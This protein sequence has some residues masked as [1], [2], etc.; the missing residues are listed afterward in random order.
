MIEETLERIRGVVPVENVLVLTNDDQIAAVRNILADYLPAENILAEPAKRDTAPAIAIAV[1]W[2]ASQ[3]RDASM[4]VLPADHLI[5]NVEAFRV[6]AQRALDAA[7]K[8]RALVTIGVFPTWACPSFGYIEQGEEVRELD[9]KFFRVRRFR[10]KPSAELA[11]SFLKAGNF[12]WN[13]GIFAWSVTSILSA[14]AAHTPELARFIERSTREGTLAPSWREEFPILPKIS[15][16][17][18]IMEKAEHV[19]E[20]DASFDWD[21][22]GGWPAMER[23][24]PKDKLENAAECGLTAIDSSHNIVRAAPGTHVA[25]L[26]V[27]D[28]I[29]IQTEDALLVADK[30]QAERIKQ[31][32]AALPAELQ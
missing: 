24:L 5:R 9:G 13:A 23:Y 31:I 2:V 10:E 14:M 27:R 29:V 26:G 4:L 19:L 21:D 11:E 28:L 8:S 25:L 22:V 1:A 20:L 18:A 6:D 3:Q 32:V 30:S 12:R 16:D 15:V 7:K 17:Y